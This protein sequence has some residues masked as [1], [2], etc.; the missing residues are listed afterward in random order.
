MFL[1]HQP[2]YFL[3][4]RFVV[5]RRWAKSEAATSFCFAVDFEL[6]R[7]RA[8]SDAALFPVAM[9]YPLPQLAPVNGWGAGAT[10]SLD[11]PSAKTFKGA[12]SDLARPRGKNSPYSRTGFVL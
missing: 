6:R 3:R 9:N 5:P 4:L 11:M 7:M 2:R 12:S 8:A 10:N 1:R